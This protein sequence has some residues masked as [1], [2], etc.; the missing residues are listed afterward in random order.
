[1]QENHRDDTD[2]SARRGS[3]FDAMLDWTTNGKVARFRSHDKSLWTS[4]E[5]N[6]A[7]D[8]RMGWL[9]IVKQQT[10]RADRF[11]K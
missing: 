5:G 9:D 11:R 1:M 4:I 8:L 3:S 10:A 7:E 2:Y 6:T